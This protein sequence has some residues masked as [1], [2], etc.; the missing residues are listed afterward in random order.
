MIT[1]N[2]S[3]RKIKDSKRKKTED[4]IKT[5]KNDETHDEADTSISDTAAISVTK[6]LNRCKL[7]HSRNTL[8]ND[9]INSFQE[10]D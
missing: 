2:K 3:P 10:F 8:E 5:N 7:I 9:Q 6:D 4:K 1:K